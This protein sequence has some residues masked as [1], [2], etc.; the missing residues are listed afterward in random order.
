MNCRIEEGRAY[1]GERAHV[2]GEKRGTPGYYYLRQTAPLKKGAVVY[3]IIE[4]YPCPENF[5]YPSYHHT[6]FRHLDQAWQWR[7]LTHTEQPP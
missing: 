3:R 4:E 7:D 1:E 6:S 2:V 5:P